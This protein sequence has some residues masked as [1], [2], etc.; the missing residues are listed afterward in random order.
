MVS[1]SPIARF[2]YRTIRICAKYYSLTRLARFP[3]STLRFNSLVLS[4]ER[5]PNSNYVFA[6]DMGISVLHVIREP[7]KAGEAIYRHSSRKQFLPWWHPKD[8]S[9][10]SQDTRQ[11]DVSEVVGILKQQT[12][13]SRAIRSQTSEAPVYSTKKKNVIGRVNCCHL[14]RQFHELL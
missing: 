8:S 4:R 2:T 10:K 7:D 14:R 11:S 12:L 3:D 13:Q 5:R 6:P 1:L 9:G